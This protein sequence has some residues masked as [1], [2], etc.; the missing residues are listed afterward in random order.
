METCFAVNN[1]GSIGVLL[2]I[3][4]PLAYGLNGKL[5]HFNRRLNFQ[6]PVF[7]ESDA[8]VPYGLVP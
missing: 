7:H 4:D 5:C 1:L 8:F 6:E 3:P 2:F